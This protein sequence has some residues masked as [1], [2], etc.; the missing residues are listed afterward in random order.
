MVEDLPDTQRQEIPA[1]QKPAVSFLK[2]EKI[3]MFAGEIIPN[4]LDTATKIFILV[5]DRHRERDI[6][7]NLVAAEFLHGISN[8]LVGVA[9]SLEQDQYPHFSCGKLKEYAE[10]IATVLQDC[11]EVD[12]LN[13]YANMLLENYQIELVFHHFQNINPMAKQQQLAQLRAAAG[14]F[15]VAGDIIQSSR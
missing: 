10:S 1:G 15:Q 2:G 13:R 7:K 5:L 9:D 12:S 11:V 4:L 14:A 3:I 8:T 6:K